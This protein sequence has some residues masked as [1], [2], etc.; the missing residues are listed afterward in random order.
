M[1]NHRMVA[2]RCANCG[3]VYGEGYTERCGPD[4]RDEQIATLTRERDAA[5]ARATQAERERDEAK[6]RAENYLAVAKHWE[7]RAIGAGYRPEK[8]QENS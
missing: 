2:G 5:S 3:A 4:P 8:G 6:K 1:S 7:S